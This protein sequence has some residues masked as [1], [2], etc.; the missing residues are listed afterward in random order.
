[1]ASSK[2]PALEIFFDWKHLSSERFLPSLFPKW[3][4]E[5][6]LASLR[7][8]PIKKSLIIVLNLVYPD[9]KSLPAKRAPFYFAN[10]TTAG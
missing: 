7:P 4:Y 6:T 2:T 1:M 10:S 9:L 8:A 3:L 5:T